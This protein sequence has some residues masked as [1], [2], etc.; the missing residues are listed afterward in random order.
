MISRPQHSDNVQEQ[1]EEGVPVFMFRFQPSTVLCCCSRRT[2]VCGGPKG[3]MALWGS[4]EREF[5]LG[6]CS[7]P[8]YTK[9]SNWQTFN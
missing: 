1:G 4:V 2:G 6:V 9:H 7:D 3:S 8:H 5:K